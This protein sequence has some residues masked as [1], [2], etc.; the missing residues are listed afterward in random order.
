M[1]ELVGERHKA[2]GSVEEFAAEPLDA[3][4][5]GVQRVAD[6]VGHAAGEASELL[7]LFGVLEFLF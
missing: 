6:L 7:Q 4:A 3:H 1:A 2:V 5:D